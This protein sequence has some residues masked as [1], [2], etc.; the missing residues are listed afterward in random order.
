MVNEAK[1]HEE[2]D[3]AAKDKV[4][5]KNHADS[6]VYQLEKQIKEHGDKVPADVKSQLEGKLASLKEAIAADD[7][8]GMKAKMKDLEESA[9]K[10]GEAIYAAQQAQ[11]GAGAPP[12]PNADNTAKA[13][14]A[15]NDGVV[16]AEVVD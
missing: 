8:E 2:E 13:E 1:A 6:M 10:M 4:E 5:T 15:N 14:S 9:M 3:K 11:Q 12:P 16:D 7:T